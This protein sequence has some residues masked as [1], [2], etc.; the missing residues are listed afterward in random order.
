MIARGGAGPVAL[1]LLL[2]SA[3]QEI[4]GSLGPDSAQARLRAD[5]L[6][7]SLSGRF[8]PVQRDGAFMERRSR[9]ARGSLVPSRAF[10][11]DA[12]WT[13]AAGPA[14]TLEFTGGWSQ[15]RYHIGVGA[16]RPAPDAPGDYRAWL[17]LRGLGSADYEWEARDEL[18]VGPVRV[19][20]LDRALT[21]L[22]RAVEGT[23]APEARARAR[24]DLPR[25][26]AALQRLFTLEALERAPAA[27]GGMRLT[28]VVTTHPAGIDR[29]F[30][31]YASYLRKYVTPIRFRSVADDQAGARWWEAEGH[32]ERTTVRLRVHAGGLAPLEGPP[33]PL[34]DRWRVRTDV[35]TKMGLFRLGVQD[36]DADVWLTREP[37]QWAFAARF[38]A[39]PDWQLPFL[40]EPLL[41]GSLRRPFEGE[42]VLFA[43]AAREDGARM[44][45]AR[46]YRLAVRESWIVR[47]LGG[48]AGTAMT[49]YWRGA[50]EE[51]DRFSGQFLE[52]L[53]RDVG[54]LIEGRAGG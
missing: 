52:A 15:G 49:E 22:W 26:T 39:A 32:G 48:L 2:A 14:R 19:A 21:A 44:L 38:R 34:P 29:E 8:G 30:P 20:D 16:A 50:E 18:S 9:L 3:C 35:S 13:S 54:A 1:G 42:G 11:D 4:A 51:A 45:L 17:R 33:R 31:R 53:R 7:A 40:V 23:P 36:L 5:R 6:L 37:R 10:R 25:T 12:L 47:W 24:A 43:V 41:R 28:V 46:D 27:G